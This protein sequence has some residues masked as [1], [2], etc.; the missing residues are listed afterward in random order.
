MRKPRLALTRGL[1]AGR[2]GDAERWRA[3]GPHARRGERPAEGPD[4]LR[5][6]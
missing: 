6:V 5:R 4:H 1:E 2:T 3:T